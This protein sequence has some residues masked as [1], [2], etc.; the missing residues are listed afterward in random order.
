MKA[1]EEARGKD[2]LE[3]P[4]KEA[5]ADMESGEP[6]RMPI[7]SPIGLQGRACPV[8]GDDMLPLSFGEYRYAVD[9]TAKQ[10][11]TKFP[12]VGNIEKVKLA[13]AWTEQE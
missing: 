11:E 2:D 8:A 10:I 1:M 13:L 6:T 4:R 7:G 5:F 9:V 3:W 12:G